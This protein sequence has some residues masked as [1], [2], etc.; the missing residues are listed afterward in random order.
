[1]SRM[2]AEG[3]GVEP[4]QGVS[5]AVLESSKLSAGP[6]DDGPFHCRSSCY[7]I[8][9]IERG[10]PGLRSSIRKRHMGYSLVRGLMRR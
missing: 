10:S 2:M 6:T 3:A 1:M 7:F 8:P 4:N 5:L 9:S